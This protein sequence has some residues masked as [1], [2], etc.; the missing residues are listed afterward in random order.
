MANKRFSF[1]QFRIELE[2]GLT[3]LVECSSVRVGDHTSQRAETWC[4]GACCQG[5]AQ[6]YNRPW[7]S[8]C[9]ETA[10]SALADKFERYGWKK[11]AEAVREWS[12]K[13]AKGEAEAAEKFASDFKKEWDAARPSLRE[14]IAAGGP[15]ENEEQAKST[16]AILK[17]GNVLN[18]LG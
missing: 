6:Y 15:I 11:W 2:P 1:Q 13:H 12:D 18:S 8:Y 17:M 10:V 3:I 5:Y 4:A 16:L 14:A 9:Y 7:E